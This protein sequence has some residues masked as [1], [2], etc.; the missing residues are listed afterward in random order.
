MNRNSRAVDDRLGHHVLEPGLVAVR[1][2]I[3]SQSSTLVAI[4]TVHITC[5]P[6]SRAAIVIG[7]A[8]SGIGELMWT[9]SMSLSLRTSA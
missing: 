5:L 6:A 9:A 3:F 4:G 2:T 1:S 7:Q 8:W